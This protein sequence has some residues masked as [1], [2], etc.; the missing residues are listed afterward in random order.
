MKAAK[1]IDKECID[2]CEAINRYNGLR[3]VESCSGHGDNIFRI[4]LH[5]DDVESLAPML[6]YLDG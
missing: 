6:F 3:T 1:D 2:L 4:F 5:V